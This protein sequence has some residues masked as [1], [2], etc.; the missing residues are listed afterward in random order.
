MKHFLSLIPIS[1]ALAGCTG[2]SGGVSHLEAFRDRYTFSHRGTVVPQREEPRTDTVIY[3]TALEFPEGYDWRRD[4]SFGEVSGRVVL[5]RDSVRVLEIPAGP[6]SLAS[7]DPDLHHLVDGHVYTESCTEDGTVIGLDG[8]ELFSYPDRELLCGLLVEGTDVYTLGRNRSGSGFSLRRNGDILFSR[9][10]GSVSAHFSARPDYPSG[11]LYRDGGHMYFSYW[12]P[13]GTHREWY[14]VEDGSESR[15]DVPD[16]RVYDIRVRDGDLELT[17]M[18]ASP[19]GVYTYAADTWKSVVAVS[20]GGGLI[21]SSPL[22]PTS[23]SFGPPVLF[24]SFRDACVFGRHLYVAMNPLASGSKPFL[25][26]D[27]EF[28]FGLDIHGFITEVSVVAE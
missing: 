18:K 15:V 12:Q 3:M 21:L 24:L 28:L 5:Y 9:P 8:T 2:A 20:R 14:V 7:L 6:G 13:Y 23:R 4:T 22:W 16:D 17:P 1:L 19:L 10:S 25:S 11:A 27:G 26:C